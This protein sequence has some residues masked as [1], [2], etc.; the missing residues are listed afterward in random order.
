MSKKQDMGRVE[1]GTRGRKGRR[2][3][4]STAEVIKSDTSG[5]K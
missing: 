3:D 4:Y 1:E 2:V 5:E